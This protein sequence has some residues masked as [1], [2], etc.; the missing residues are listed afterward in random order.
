MKKIALLLALIMMLGV[1]TAC[2]SSGNSKSKNAESTKVENTEVEETKED[3]EEIIEEAEKKPSI[4]AFELV[5][6]PK[7]LSYFENNEEVIPVKLEEID[8]T[9]SI[10]PVEVAPDL[11]N[12]GYADRVEFSEAQLNKILENKFLVTKP[13]KFSDGSSYDQIFQIYE[14][15]EYSNFPN[16]VTTDSIIHLYHLFYDNFLMDIEENQLLPALKELTN[17]MLMES[18]RQHLEVE[19]PEIKELAARNA[20]FF[21]VAMRLLDEPITVSSFAVGMDKAVAEL[22]KIENQAQDISEINK[23]AVDFSQMKV[24]GHYTKSENLEK[25]F[26]TVMYYGQIGM[27][28]TEDGMLRED[29]V[30]QALLMTEALTR[31][32]ENFKLWSAV[33]DPMNFLVENGD[34]LSV[35]DFGP[36]L[37][38]VYGDEPDLN[39]LLDEEKLEKILIFVS[40]LSEPQV[41]GFMGHSFRFL[42]QRAVIDSVWMQNLVEVSTPVQPS[43]KPLYSGL[44]LLGVMGDEMA[45]SVVK[46]DDFVKQ[47]PEYDDRFEEVKAYIEELNDEFWKKNIY[48]GWIWSLT[49]F[50]DGIRGEG[51]PEF[52]KNENYKY[53]EWNTALGSY[54]ELKHDTV[55]YGK[56]VMAEMG[57][58]F[59][60]EMP[61]G[62]IEPNV[63][64]YE[65]LTWLVDFTY[66]NLADRGYLTEKNKESL[67]YLY[68][69]MK[70]CRDT[71]VKELE[72][73]PLTQEE[74]ERIYMIGGEMESIAMKFLTEDYYHW[75]LLDEKDRNMAIVSD[76]MSIPENT[77]DIPRG[78]IVSLGIGE[79]Y[80][81][82]AIYQIGDELVLG[83]GGVFSYREFLSEERLNDE[84]WQ[85]QLKQNIAPDVTE[86]LKQTMEGENPVIIPEETFF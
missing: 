13:E 22:N 25:Y 53:K 51:Y 54:A 75:S 41:G 23:M 29:L 2:G 1:F 10:V 8:Y 6:I 37:Y 24:R 33:F 66:Q 9:P 34:D 74:Y 28:M 79:P 81:I 60:E 3:K 70:F 80:P 17:N 67:N 43:R 82:F 19:D 26:K 50:T 44:E 15:N 57:G 59:Y 69:L 32:E 36:I 14:D 73:I 31:D 4:S 38:N 27:F 49:E 35:R 56:Q 21:T 86:V 46:G 78:M 11:S 72:N 48:R 40:E 52:M 45:E 39:E 64:L 42:P 47:W 65:K 84:E 83:K 61:R 5:K 20:A 77:W 68:D 76:L 7:R 71:S 62:Y 30:A 18:I 58:P 63:E 55:L 12:V 85:A 16:F